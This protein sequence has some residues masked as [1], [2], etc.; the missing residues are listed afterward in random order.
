MALYTYAIRL[1]DNHDS[2]GASPRVKLTFGAT[3]RERERE[4]ERVFRLSNIEL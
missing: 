4:R 2:Q 3:Q 1:T